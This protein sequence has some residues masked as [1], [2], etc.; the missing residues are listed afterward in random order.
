MKPK[1]TTTDEELREKRIAQLAA[2]VDCDA[3]ELN[4][5]IDAAL[6]KGDAAKRALGDEA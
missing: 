6:A 3:R 4:A 1:Q 2:R 5:K